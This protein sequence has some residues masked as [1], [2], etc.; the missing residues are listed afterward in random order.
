MT[1]LLLS[2][3][4][5]SQPFTDPSIL[6]VAIRFGSLACQLMSVMERAWAK[7]KRERQDDGDVERK[8]QINSFCEEVV[9]M[10]LDVTG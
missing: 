5:R 7:I 10:R 2:P 9:K 6:V 3:T 4:R 8:S 1:A